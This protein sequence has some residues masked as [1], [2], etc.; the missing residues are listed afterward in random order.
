MKQ[1]FGKLYEGSNPEWVIQSYFDWIYDSGYF[2]E[3]VSNVV[4]KRSFT[5]DDVARRF[6]NVDSYFEEDH[7]EGVELIVALRD[8]DPDEV[9]V[10]MASSGVIFRLL[11]GSV[12][13]RIRAIGWQSLKPWSSFLRGRQVQ[14]VLPLRFPID[15]PRGAM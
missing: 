9:R 8:P 12:L 2:V 4:K 11:A 13:R 10:P 7:F 15:L 5:T 6:P 3:M 14:Q 1:L